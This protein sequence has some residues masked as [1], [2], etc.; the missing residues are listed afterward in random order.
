MFIVSLNLAFCYD[1]VLVKNGYL[2]RVWRDTP[3]G[4]ANGW[5]DLDFRIEFL[6][7]FDKTILS[8]VSALL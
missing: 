5:K 4:D 6:W 8:M 1:V 3:T 7:E 2:V